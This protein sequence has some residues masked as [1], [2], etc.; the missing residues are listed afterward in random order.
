MK[1]DF[2]FCLNFF[3]VLTSSVTFALPLRL[4]VADG[5]LAARDYGILVARQMLDGALAS[6]S[7]T[8]R[9]AA[10]IYEDLERR[11]LPAVVSFFSPSPVLG[12]NF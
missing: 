6:E 8:A 7:L 2:F 5:G 10:L 11:V 4:P 9:E 12:R 1:L 3:C